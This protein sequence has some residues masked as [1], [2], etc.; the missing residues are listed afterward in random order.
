MSKQAN[1]QSTRIVPFKQMGC[2]GLFIGYK[3]VEIFDLPELFGIIEKTSIF[4]P[5]LSYL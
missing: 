1:K 5:A 2:F 4:P 3:V